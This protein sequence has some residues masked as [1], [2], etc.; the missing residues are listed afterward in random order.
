[1][2]L[3]HRLLIAATLLLVTGCAS[4]AT[5]RFADNL[6]NAML[7][8]SDP[9]IIRSGAPAYLLL[10]ESLIEDSPK[11]P[12]L[13]FA[14]AR[15][16]SAYSGGLVEDPQRRRILARKALDYA[17]RGLCSS[18]P[19]IC[20]TKE[21]P[22]DQFVKTLKNT[23]RD[24]MEGLYLFAT[25]WAG[26]IEANSEDWSAIANLPKVE[27]LLEKVIA[28]DP[29]FEKGRAQLYL[30][31]IR[32]QLPPTLGGRPEVGRAHF[33]Q[34]LAFCEGNDLIVK[35]EFARTYA[36]LVFD[37][38]LHDRLLHEVLNADPL[39]PGL[40]LSNVIAQQRAKALL[41]DEYF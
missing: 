32:S 35:V 33:E 4:L 19:R 21:R 38:A 7:N 39:V 9:E 27:A 2:G 25:S 31:V 1:M 26:W 18:H 36:R 22:Y 5:G 24:D 41:E 28:Q 17:E 6:A 11:D 15:L 3:F 16:Y 34:A 12:D 20:T 23:E 40:T 8:Q 30:G 29:G 37:Q 13:L 14:A 10:L